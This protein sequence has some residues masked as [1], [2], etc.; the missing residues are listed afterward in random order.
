MANVSGNVTSTPA[1]VAPQVDPWLGLRVGIGT[2]A[3]IVFI[4]GFFGNLT[5]LVTIIKNKRKGMNTLMYYLICNLAVYDI[6]VMIISLPMTIVQDLAFYWVFGPVLCRITLGLPFL[7]AA[8][9]ITTMVAIAI[10]PF[11][12]ALPSIIYTQYD[13]SVPGYPQCGIEFST[14]PNQQMESLRIYTIAIFVILFITPLLIVVCIYSLIL[15]EIHR[16]NNKANLHY[17]RAY[18]K[19]NRKT[20]KM[21]LL[22]SVTFIMCWIPLF[23]CF[24]I[25]AYGAVTNQ[26]R[27]TFFFIYAVSHLVSY[28]NSAANPLIYAGF[29]SRFRKSLWYVFSLQIVKEISEHRCGLQSR[30]TKVMRL[31]VSKRQ[32][33]EHRQL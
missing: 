30:E 33:S 25:I 4:L 21:M 12:F 9:S 20:I 31:S 5:I 17:N 7:F 10:D 24:F 6:L 23:I 14:D 28:C 8:G 15:Y 27:I 13:T 29:T 32:K 11:S 2:A 19:A 16:R 22:V 26:T 3:C 18:G 1:A